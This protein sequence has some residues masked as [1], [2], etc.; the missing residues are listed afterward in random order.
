ME[1]FVL[2]IPSTTESLACYI[3]S[4]TIVLSRFGSCACT[5]PSGASRDL[6]GQHRRRS[7]CTVTTAPEYPQRGSG[8]GPQSCVSCNSLLCTAHRGV[9]ACLRGSG[10]SA[11]PSS[12]PA[13][14]DAREA[15]TESALTSST[16]VNQNEGSDT[17]SWT[18]R[19]H[20]ARRDVGLTN[21]KCCSGSTESNIYTM[22]VAT[23][24]VRTLH[25]KEESE[26]RSRFGGT[27]MV[28]KVEILE[29]A[30]LK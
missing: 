17:T 13:E 3:G 18:G 23:A 21:E 30:T 20:R 24:N 6:Y 4:S 8:S 22:T 9:S 12:R 7:Q 2:F 28:G 14:E 15:I 16:H 27:L 19:S 1:C 29:I 25:P 26:S 11:R 10:T 5:R